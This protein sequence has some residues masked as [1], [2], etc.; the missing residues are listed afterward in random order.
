MAAVFVPDPDVDRLVSLLM[1]DLELHDGTWDGDSFRGF[2]E[3]RIQML[4]NLRLGVTT[5]FDDPLVIAKL[6]S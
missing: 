5:E 6:K 4:V 2:A 3:Y 1:A